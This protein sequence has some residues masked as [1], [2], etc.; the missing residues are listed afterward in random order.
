M[1]FSKI[2]G[3]PPLQNNFNSFRI[4]TS[5]CLDERTCTC[6]GEN[7]SPLVEWLFNLVMKFAGACQTEAKGELRTFNS[8]RGNANLQYDDGILF[9]NY[10]SGDK[11][12]NNQFERNTIISFICSPN[13]GQGHPEFIAETDDCTYQFV[14]HTSL[15]CEEQ[16]SGIIGKIVETMIKIK[17]KIL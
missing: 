2:S 4:H 14:W 10:S 13:A 16:V 7:L 11:C 3:I 9:L 5:K 12:H 17:S 6:S 1:E 8:G 15:A